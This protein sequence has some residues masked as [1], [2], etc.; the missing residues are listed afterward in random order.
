MSINYRL[1]RFAANVKLYGQSIP[2][3]HQPDSSLPNV[4][5]GAVA[6][7]IQARTKSV[8]EL[9]NNSIG[10]IFELLVAMSGTI[11]ADDYSRLG[12]VV[13]NEGLESGDPAIIMNVRHPHSLLILG[14]TSDPQACF[15]CMQCAEKA[16]KTFL[17][18]VSS[19]MQ[20]CIRYYFLR[21]G[22]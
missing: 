19:Y 13:W 4:D 2:M 3:S 18:M 22:C 20:R 5:L 10:P 17:G 12:P 16:S 7:T 8:A 15:L 11:K 9:P 1:L 21:E 6:T 14:L